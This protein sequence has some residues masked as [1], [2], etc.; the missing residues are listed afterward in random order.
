MLKIIDLEESTFRAGAREAEQAARTPSL[1]GSSDNGPTMSW[2]SKTGWIAGCAAR[3]TPA[4]LLQ[5][6]ARGVRRRGSGVPLPRVQ[7]THGVL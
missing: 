5:K 3:T 7:P 4:K 1:L 2:R 6:A